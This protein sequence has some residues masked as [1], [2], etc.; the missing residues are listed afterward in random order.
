MPPTWGVGGEGRAHSNACYS[1]EG[2]TRGIG[3]GRGVCLVARCWC[4]NGGVDIY[5]GWGRPETH[6]AQRVLKAHHA[7]QKDGEQL[8]GAVEGKL[9]AL[10]L[11]P[12]VQLGLRTGREGRKQGHRLVGRQ[13]TLVEHVAKQPRWIAVD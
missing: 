7:S 4:V 10:G 5:Q 2:L 9:A 12:W 1:L 3:V 13:I 8:V 11:A 6:H